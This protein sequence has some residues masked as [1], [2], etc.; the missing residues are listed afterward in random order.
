MAISRNYR[1]LIFGEVFKINTTHFSWNSFNVHFAV[2]LTLLILQQLCCLYMLLRLTEKQDN[3]VWILIYPPILQ[4]TVEP[5]PFQSMDSCCRLT[6]TQQKV[7]WQC[8]SVTQGLSQRGWWQQCVRVM[9][10]GPPTQETLPAA[11]DRHPHLHRPHRHQ[12]PLRL[13]F[14]P[15]RIN[16]CYCLVQLAVH[17]SIRLC[18]KINR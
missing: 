12:H 1:I 17:A 8:S 11:P 4:L 3:T 10:S 13:L 2:L 5:C 18:K 9:V 6:P 7:Q 15:V 16:F 14:P